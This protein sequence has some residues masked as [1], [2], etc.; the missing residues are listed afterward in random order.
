MSELTT[1]AGQMK[2]DGSHANS[3][4]LEGGDYEMMVSGCL[5]RRR[6][7]EGILC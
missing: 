2:L 4:G 3:A 1:V 7:G 5:V 6:K